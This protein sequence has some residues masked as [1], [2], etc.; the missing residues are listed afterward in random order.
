[1]KKKNRVR[2]RG[3]EVM[4][5][6]LAKRDD[7]RRAFTPGMAGNDNL[8]LTLSRNESLARMGEGAVIGAVATSLMTGAVTLDAAMAV[9]AFGGAVAAAVLAGWLYG[10]AALGR[11]LAGWWWRW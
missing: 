1:M 11:M 6:V 9:T 4:P 10:C 8:D 5:G 3:A 2:R 7:G